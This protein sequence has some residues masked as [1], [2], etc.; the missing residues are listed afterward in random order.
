MMQDSVL[1]LFGYLLRL[2]R[3]LVVL[4][5]FSMDSESLGKL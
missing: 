4:A 3:P 2:S 5:L 1:L